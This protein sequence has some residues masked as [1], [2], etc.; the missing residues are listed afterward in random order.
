[1]SKSIE[2]LVPELREKAMAALTVHERISVKTIDAANDEVIESFID[3]FGAESAAAP[4]VRVTP[5]EKEV[6]ST[7]K[8]CDLLAEKHSKYEAEFVVRG[9]KALYD[10]L[11]GIYSVAL[12][13]NKS[14]FRFE[15]L[16]MLR[17]ALSE[18]GIKTQLNTP[19]LTILIKYIAG[20]NRKNAANYSRVLRVALEDK[21][22]ANAL[23]SYISRRG[24]MGQV[25]TT[26]G[27]ASSKESIR[28]S[29]KE[30]LALVKEFLKLS[31]WESGVEFKYDKPVSVCNASK[32]T[33]QETSSFCFFLADFDEPNNVYRIIQ[34]YDLGHSYE[35]NVL[36]FIIKDASNDLDVIKDGVVRLKKRLLNKTG[37]PERVLEDIRKDLASTDKK[38]AA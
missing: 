18:R 31:Q 15:T 38:L 30:K 20:A 34:S 28:D 24:G 3:V 7:I 12:R 27:K 33:A 1:M 29:N 26:E 16:S 11:Q 14:E 5:K 13:I 8:E 17:S 9:N 21:V 25:H 4:T 35:S 2:N 19:D 6:T 37:V 32:Q 23:T 10:L 22:P 36:R